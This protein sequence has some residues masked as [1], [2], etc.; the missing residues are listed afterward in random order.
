MKR[1]MLLTLLIALFVWGIIPGF[2]QTTEY[3]F[4]TT[5]GTYTPISGGLLL[6]TETSDDQRFVDPDAP[7]G[8]TVTTGPGIPIGFDFMFNGASFD[9]L[10]VNNNGWISL[11]Q[12]ALTPSVNI[13]SSSAYTPIASTTAIDP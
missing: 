12:S 4:T 1:S 7:A 2:A 8:S 10:A 5:M 13:A 3:G 11:G 9:R 6:G